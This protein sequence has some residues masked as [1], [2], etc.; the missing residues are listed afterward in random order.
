MGRNGEDRSVDHQEK[1]KRRKQRDFNR[2]ARNFRKNKGR[3]VLGDLASPRQQRTGFGLTM[4]ARITIS[5]AMQV[6][7][8]CL[9][10]FAFEITSRANHSRDETNAHKQACN[11]G[12]EKSRPTRS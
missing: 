4:M 3:F 10:R 11:H 5:S 1:H 12:E 6:S 8:M 9:R 2:K 7:G